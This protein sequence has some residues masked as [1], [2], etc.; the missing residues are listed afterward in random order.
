[1]ATQD[2]SDDTSAHEG[3][4]TTPEDSTINEVFARLSAMLY[5]GADSE[6]VHQA[7][8]D[9]CPTLVE[10]CDRAAIML[11]ERDRYR[12]AA[13]TDAV[14]AQ[15]DQL[16]LRVGEGPCLDAIRDEA[17][18]HDPDL[19]DS[20]G[21]WPRFT[22]AIVA[23]TPVRSAIGYRLM[24][25]GD[26]VG[27]LNLFSDSPNGLTRR[28]ADAG[29]VL[30]SFSSVAMMALRARTEATTLREGL[31][32]NREIGKAVGLLMAAHR[33]GADEAFG[34]LRRTSQELNVK[35][36]QV[37]SQVVAGQED[38]YAGRRSEG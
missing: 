28:A 9:A 13:A 29:A 30:A 20:V 36:A 19:S 24:L 4:V 11:R 23:E 14:A 12:T 8:V 37:A 34:I 33:V 6:S 22:A 5:S 38:Q 7:L 16:E 1:M 17:Y 31:R 35:L 10:G 18:Q 32:S 25:D 3:S 2:P 21:P 27:A 26:K 15:I